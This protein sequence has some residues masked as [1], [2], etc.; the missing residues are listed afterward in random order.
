MVKKREG[1]Y[2][3]IMKEGD[4]YKIGY[5]KRAERRRKQLQTGSSR[6]IEVIHE[7]KCEEREAREVER[8]LQRMCMPY[9]IRGEWYLLPPEMV[10]YL[11]QFKTEEQVYKPETV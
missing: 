7:I 1:G 11:L 9:H 10:L 3:Y 6:V 4:R 5:S 2:V 8:R